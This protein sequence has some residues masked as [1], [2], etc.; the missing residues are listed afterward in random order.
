MNRRVAHDQRVTCRTG[1]PHQ[2]F[3]R[4]DE[5]WNAS[6]AHAPVPPRPAVHIGR[7]DGI[8]DRFLADLDGRVEL[9]FTK[10]VAESNR[11]TR[12][13]EA[14]ERAAA[15][16]EIRRTDLSKRQAWDVR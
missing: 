3:G 10:H 7:D 9:L 15:R 5:R 4:A 6:T 1:G 12:A 16:A 11:H 14:A 13:H 8:V 2:R